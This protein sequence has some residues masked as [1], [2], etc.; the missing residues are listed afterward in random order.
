MIIMADRYLNQNVGPEL[1]WWVGVSH[2]QK[3]F[4]LVRGED[5]V[6]LELEIYIARVQHR[7]VQSDTRPTTSCGML[8]CSLLIQAVVSV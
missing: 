2:F 3:F 5:V 7:H 8:L 6:G 1:R 4:Y